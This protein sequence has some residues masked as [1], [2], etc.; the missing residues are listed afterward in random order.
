MV[1]GAVGQPTARPHR[2]PFRGFGCDSVSLEGGRK[3]KMAQPTTVEELC[4]LQ[5]ALI[6]ALHHEFGLDCARCSSAHVPSEPL[7]QHL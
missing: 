7:I 1:V 2:L 5:T 4:R 3:K 6:A